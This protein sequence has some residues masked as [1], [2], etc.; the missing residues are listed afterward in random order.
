MNNIN[1]NNKN[2]IKKTGYERKGLDSS[3][4]QQHLCM[5]GFANPKFI[6]HMLQRSLLYHWENKYTL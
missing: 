4:Q 3:T 5:G 1:N 2:K 6:Y